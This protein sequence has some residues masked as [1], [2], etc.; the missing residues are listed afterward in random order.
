MKSKKMINYVIQ[1]D[2]FLLERVLKHLSIVELSG[3]KQINR[4]FCN[5]INDILK[6]KIGVKST[7]EKVHLKLRTKF[8]LTVPKGMINREYVSAPFG[9]V[10]Q[11]ASY[12][13]P[14]Y[15]Y[16]TN[17]IRIV[18]CFGCVFLIYKKMQSFTVNPKPQIAF[19]PFKKLD[20][21]LLF[22]IRSLYL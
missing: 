12:Y 18:D 15:K 13:T 5:L 16:Y 20:F 19:Y 6:R 9:L 22:T 17:E 14:L 4:D 10:F 11:C 8:P 21:I 1:L 3:C 7:W 2:L